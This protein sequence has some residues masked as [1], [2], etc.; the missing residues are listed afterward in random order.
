L[1][2]SSAWF[3]S[4]TAH[5]AAFRWQ[6]FDYFV[7]RQ[8]RYRDPGCSTRVTPGVSIRDL[9]V[10]TAFSV[11]L[12]TLALQGLTLKPLL[13]AGLA[14]FDG[15]RSPV[16]EAVRLEFTAHLA[17][18]GADPEAGDSR[19]SAHSEIHRNGRRQFLTAST[20]WP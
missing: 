11:V 19:R 14:S 1:K 9:I 13:R 2:D 15:D 5:A 7:G 8:A 18:T 4:T 6:R 3:S 16:A 17:P 20:G 10:L 12:G